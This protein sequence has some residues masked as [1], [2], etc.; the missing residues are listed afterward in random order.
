[1]SLLIAGIVVWWFAMRLDRLGNQLEAVC[2]ELQIEMAE[3]IGNEERARELR[4]EWKQ[5]QDEQKK[6]TRRMWIFMA[7]VIGVSAFAWWLFT[8]SQH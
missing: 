4:D 3:L 6:A 2:A 7:G 5:N 1:M 8:V